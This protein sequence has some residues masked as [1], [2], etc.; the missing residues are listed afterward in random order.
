MTRTNQI[1][2][3]RLGPPRRR[4]RG[5]QTDPDPVVVSPIP[6]AVF[7]ALLGGLLGGQSE[8]IRS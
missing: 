5:H 2:D 8:R 6:K 1:A 7:A 3:A 4:S